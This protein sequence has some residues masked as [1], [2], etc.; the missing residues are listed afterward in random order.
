M[1]TAKNIIE[2]IETISSTLKPGGMWINFGPLQYHFA[3]IQEYSIE[4]TLEQIEKVAVSYGFRIDVCIVSYICILT[5]Y[6]TKNCT[7]LPHMW[8][9]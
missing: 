8:P 2:Y 6:S 5:F 7:V 3:E 9:M 1:D 4:L